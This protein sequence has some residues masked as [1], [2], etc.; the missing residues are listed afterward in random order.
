M[1]IRLKVIDRKR[2]IMVHMRVKRQHQRWTLPY[3]PHAS[4]AMTMDPAFVAFG[5]FAPTLQVHIVGRKLSRLAPHKQPQFKAAHPLGKM[6]LNGIRAGRPFL[7]QRAE[8]RLTLRARGR[9]ARPEGTIHCLQ[10]LGVEANVRQRIPCDIESAV[11]AAG[12]TFQQR[13]C[14]PP[15]LA[16]RLRSSDSRTSCNASLIRTPGG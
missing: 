10:G 11:N 4:V 13:R 9:G 2:T 14:R 1:T 6:L 7:L 3:D 5:T 16:C 12:Q 15:F 8:L